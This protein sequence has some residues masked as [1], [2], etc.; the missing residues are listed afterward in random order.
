[1]S[2]E[3]FSWVIESMNKK[4][5]EKAQRKREEALAAKQKAEL[6]GRNGAAKWAAARLAMLNAEA[7]EAAAS[8]LMEDPKQPSEPKAREQVTSVPLVLPKAAADRNGEVKGSVIAKAVAGD[9]GKAKRSPSS[10]TTPSHNATPRSVRLRSKKGNTAA[11]VGKA[12]SAAKFAGGIFF[13][14]EEHKQLKMTI[15]R[16]ERRMHALECMLEKAKGLPLDDLEDELQE[17]TANAYQTD[18]EI[19]IERLLARTGVQSGSLQTPLG[20]PIPMP[21]TV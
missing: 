6:E 4:A 7:V 9:D 21:I 13:T 12:R 16:L 10:S 19:D 2:N 14:K 17:E 15:Q 20:K 3:E 5:E 18:S 1:V 11:Q 8:A